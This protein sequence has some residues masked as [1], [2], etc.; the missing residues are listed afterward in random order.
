MNRSPSRPPAVDHGQYDHLS[1]GQLREQCK[2]R[3]YS[4]KDSEAVLKTRL[5]VMDAEGSKRT[6]VESNDTDSTVSVSGKRKRPT[7]DVAD[8]LE[9]YHL[10]QDERYRVD[11]VR[12]AFTADMEVVQAR[13]RWR[14]PESKVKS[15]RHSGPCGGGSGC[16]DFCMG[17]GKLQSRFGS[18]I[19]G[20]GRISWRPGARCQSQRGGTSRT[21]CQYQ[22]GAHL[23][24]SGWREV[25]RG[26]PD[27]TRLPVP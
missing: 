15:G 1:Y 16:R 10:S 9:G 23:E 5:T 27:S 11:A 14:N 21:R 8:H 25:S 18:G 13:A 17:C 19:I 20:G 26:E 3:R 24:D 12:A 22:M 6:L 2:P 7:V 4:R